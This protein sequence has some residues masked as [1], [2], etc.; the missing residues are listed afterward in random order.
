LKVS[1]TVMDPQVGV[2][3]GA[4]LTSAAKAL[5]SLVVGPVGLLA[6]FAHLGANKAHPCDVK[7]V[8]QS[9]PKNAGEERPPV[10]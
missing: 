7:G 3:K 10:P 8:G 6:P 2:D 9:A 1:G 5:S 4:L